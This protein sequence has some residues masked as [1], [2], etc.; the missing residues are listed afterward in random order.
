MHVYGMMHAER[1][2]AGDSVFLISYPLIISNLV[3]R[4]TTRLKHPR[5]IYRYPAGNIAGYFPS[6]DNDLK[7]RMGDRS[8][9]GACEMTY[10]RT[11]N[12]SRVGELP[13]K[14]VMLANRRC[15]SDIPSLRHCSGRRRR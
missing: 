14:E 13:S 9:D 1:T 2:R 7:Q 3:P 8:R 15:L 5:Y 10:A 4:Y 12:G 6:P 11:C